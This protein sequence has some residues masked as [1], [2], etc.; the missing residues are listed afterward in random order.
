MSEP[1]PDPVM[2]GQLEIDLWEHERIEICILCGGECVEF[3]GE[4]CE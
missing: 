2:P 1:L 4:D 3:D